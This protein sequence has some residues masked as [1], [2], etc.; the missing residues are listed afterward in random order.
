M[1][2]PELIEAVAAKSGVAK[3]E[4]ESTVNALL[5][6]MSESLASGEEISIAGYLKV[7]RVLRSARKGR[8]PRTGEQ[9]DIPASHSAKLTA[10]SKLKAAAK[11]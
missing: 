10:G 7:E 6:V 4:V 1:K 2:K 3:S 9:I 8:N 11:G 5:E